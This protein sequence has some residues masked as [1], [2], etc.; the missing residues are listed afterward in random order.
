V[1]AVP[2]AAVTGYPADL[3]GLV[4]TPEWPVLVLPK[5]VRLAQI[6]EVLRLLAGPAPGGDPGRDVAGA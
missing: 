6:L 2:L 1:A 3:D 5:P 4:D